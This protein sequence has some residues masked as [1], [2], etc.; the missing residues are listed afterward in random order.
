[1]SAFNEYDDNKK[2]DYIYLSEV[3]ANDGKEFR[4][5]ELL[6]NADGMPLEKTNET[7][8]TVKATIV[9]DITLYE[10]STGQQKIHCWIEK[11]KNGKPFTMGLRIARRTKKGVYGGQ[12]ICLNLDATKKLKNFI[13]YIFSEDFSVKSKQRISIDKPISSYKTIKISEK[14]FQDIMAFNIENIHNYGAILEIKRREETIKELE[15]IINNRNVYK[16]E[17]DI[18]KFLK[19]NIWLFNNEYVFFSENSH[20]NAMNIL[21]LMPNTFDGFIDIIELKL[22]TVKIFNYDKSH[23]NYYPSSELTK[24]I[25]QCMNYINEM[26]ILS[27]E[28][29]KYFKPK[30]TIIIGNERELTDDEIKYL[31]LLNSSFH[32]VKIN[33]YQQLLNKAKN[34]L[35]F[36]QKNNSI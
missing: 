22:P 2:E 28:N 26:E 27:V 34:S 14:E 19:Q 11:Y 17:N 12:E 20:I 3:K 25:A 29:A 6:L 8:Q 24:A 23:Y 36:M 10:T 32:N 16:N 7:N 13:E 33:T 4:K 18:Q 31:R 1:M 15:K 30:A 21:D 5:A 9:Q 35:S